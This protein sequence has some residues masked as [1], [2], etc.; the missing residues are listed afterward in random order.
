MGDVHSIV[1]T[2]HGRARLKLYMSRSDVD[3]K[4][5]HCHAYR[6]R[7]TVYRARSAVLLA[8]PGTQRAHVK[9]QHAPGS[10]L[11]SEAVMYA[12]NC[13]PV[14]ACVHLDRCGAT[15]ATCCVLQEMSP[16]WGVHVAVGR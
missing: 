5:W 7:S 12:V 8:C 2:A 14:R 4:E 16:E 3:V 15:P 10:K 9:T 11:R 6:L 1:N 13:E